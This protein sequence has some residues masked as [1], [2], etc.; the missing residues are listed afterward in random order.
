[1]SS[2]AVSTH[3]DL[4]SGAEPVSW[5]AWRLVIVAM[6]ISFAMGWPILAKVW[7]SGYF[8]DTDDA[9]RMVQVRDLLAG[10]YWFDMTIYRLNPPEGLFNHWS[11]IV[12]IPLAVFVKLFEVFLAPQTAER[13]ARIAF[14]TSMLL[15]LLAG[16]ARGAKSLAGEKAV[17]PVLMLA[18][19][20]GVGVGQFQ[21]GRIDHHAPQIVIL[22][23][24]FALSSQALAD[25]RHRHAGYAAA[26]AALSFAIS[27]ENLTFIAA[28]CA[29]WM[30]IWVWRGADFR[31]QLNAFGAGLLIG[32]P[33]MFAATIAPSRW[34]TAACDAYSIAYLIPMMLVGAGYVTAA[35]TN[36]PTIRMRLA[37]A[38]ALAIA[39][40]ATFALLFP[41]CL[42]GPLASID[43][44]LRSYWLGNV[45]EAR[46]LLAS[47]SAQPHHTILTIGPLLVCTLFCI[48][49]FLRSKD[50]AAMRWM[51]LSMLAIA[52][53][54][55]TFWQVRAASSLAP[56]ACLAGTWAVLQIRDVLERRN[57]HT[58]PVLSLAVILFVTPTGWAM[59]QAAASALTR[60]AAAAS[61][62]DVSLASPGS[63]NCFDSTTYSQLA[64]LPA[65]L[66]AAPIDAG[67][68][69]LAH[70]H[71]SVLAAAYH[72]NNAG[73]RRL[74]DILFASPPDSQRLLNESKVNYVA[75][76]RNAAERLLL[77]RFAPHGLGSALYDGRM[78]DGL[79]IISGPR[80]SLM[81]FV[82][83]SAP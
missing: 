75:L 47:L 28:L 53:V 34:T 64:K 38:T 60:P 29:F 2:A 80:D 52:G 33:I 6:A 56:L 7:G 44:L 11:R 68:H 1:M 8:G 49:A 3:N 40:C 35:A 51:L 78:P 70:T 10:Q 46:S 36:A 59:F 50:I 12:D 21:P 17:L 14:S 18:A 19:F 62:I 72:R 57:L 55:T 58:A 16:V 31:R 77:Q 74:L 66:V 48:P 67:A 76:C 61:M 27:I 82:V 20:A 83:N 71:H 63:G 69:I 25:G 39:I 32:L 4:P 30:L 73:N 26:L 23:F 81:I 41:Q 24:M 42:R 22:V 13:A 15:L 45:H 5:P 79:R 65:G 43:P 37:F 9:L 54:V